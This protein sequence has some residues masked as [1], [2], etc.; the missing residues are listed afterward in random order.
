M[1]SADRIKELVFVL[2]L[3]ACTS[4]T[5]SSKY[6]LTGVWMR[7]KEI[8]ANGTEINYPDERGQSFYK[9]YADDGTY[10][11]AYMRCRDGKEMFYPEGKRTWE[12][13][14]G[15]Y[16]E[17]GDMMD[18]VIHSAD[19]M[20]IK[21]NGNTEIWRR[22]SEKE[23][24]HVE[25]AGHAEQIR[26]AKDMEAFLLTLSEK[27][28]DGRMK[29]FW[30]AIG[31]LGLIAAYF[32]VY[33]WMMRRKKKATERRLQ[34]IEERNRM[35]PKKM[36]DAQA[37]VVADFFNSD[38]YVQLKQRIE[39]DQRFTP[40]D[41]KTMDDAL[42]PVYP[43]FATTLRTL[44]I[45]ETEYRVSLLL[46]LR[47]PLKDISTVMCKDAATISTIRSRLYQKVFKKKGSSRDWDNFIKKL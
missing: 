6:D 23:R 3:T 45:S 30:W 9:V 1:L 7:A 15:R 14:D 27:E 21:W 26:Q 33:A 13:K 18:A 22:L 39:K 41:W 37:E 25:E 17:N 12:V 44:H 29:A 10:Y 40:N 31:A 28:Y 4:T 32:F 2:L 42:R 11:F 16:I 19:S 38:Y 43:Y 5:P 46:K 47:V 20:T 35:M 8:Q 34:E 36:A 24:D